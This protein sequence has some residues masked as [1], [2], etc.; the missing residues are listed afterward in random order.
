MKK[1]FILILLLFLSACQIGLTEHQEIYD[2]TSNSERMEI[3][4]TDDHVFA[5][6]AADAA[7]MNEHGAIFISPKEWVMGGMPFFID[8]QTHD[9]IGITYTINENASRLGNSID[10]DEDGYVYL[11]LNI[12]AQQNIVKFASYAHPRSAEESQVK[13]VREIGDG[14]YVNFFVERDVL[15]V[16][17]PRIEG[18]YFIYDVITHSLLDNSED[19]I[20]RKTFSRTN[21]KGEVIPN[22]F[23]KNNSIIIYRLE[24]DGDVTRHFVDEYDFFG[25]KIF[26]YQV[27]IDDFLYMEE[28]NSEDSIIRLFRF[29][30]YIVFITF[31]NRIAIYKLS[32]DSLNAID[33]PS[34]L[35]TIGAATVVNHF[36]TDNNLVYF[37][38]FSDTLYIF[39]LSTEEFLT[40]EISFEL[41][42]I[43]FME[44]SISQILKDSSGNLLL[45]K[46]LDITEY[47]KWVEEEQ[48]RQQNKGEESPWGDIFPLGTSRFFFLSF[49]ELQSF[50]HEE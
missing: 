12:N 7:F 19:V 17:E 45:Q 21:G 42:N 3:I 28:V 35:Q 39:D 15:I 34:S 47:E 29:K 43:Q 41:Y 50:F 46:R 33:M 6:R 1:I 48:Q 26:S 24:I 11:A 23:V 44:D 8:R 22:I 16:F 25:T 2:S 5:I 38:N 4:I 20:V 31:H 40:I 18:D 30:D 49:E 13:V 14:L 37:W 36:A 9:G 32:D 10:F 27:E